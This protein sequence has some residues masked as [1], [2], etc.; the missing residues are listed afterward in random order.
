MEVLRNQWTVFL[1]MIFYC[2]I[3][4]DIALVNAV[5][6]NGCNPSNQCPVTLDAKLGLRCELSTTGS[7][8]G[9]CVGHWSSYSNCSCTEAYYRISAEKDLYW[10][11]DDGSWEDDFKELQCLAPCTT[12]ADD[13]AIPKNSDGNVGNII[14]DS[15]YV[16][17]E[18]PPGYTS[19]GTSI[20]QCNNG[21]WADHYIFMCYGNCSIPENYVPVHPDEAVTFRNG[22]VVKMK[23]KDG[24]IPTTDII[25]TCQN[26]TFGDVP[27]CQSEFPCSNPSPQDK[28]VGVTPNQTT[29]NNGSIIMYTCPNGYYLQGDKGSVCVDGNWTGENETSCIGR[30]LLYRK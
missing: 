20:V 8:N 14:V 13:R 30:I 11:L 15:D 9:T 17:Y 6:A 23:C 18:C 16:V 27:Y 19:E 7:S 1:I 26:E 3:Q 29:Y 25:R 2:L 28:L 22:D 10:C 5:H 12:D 24:Y 4:T 21:T